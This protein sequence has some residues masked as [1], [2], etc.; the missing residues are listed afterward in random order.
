MAAATEQAARQQAELR[1]VRMERYMA[2]QAAEVEQAK[3]VRQLSAME[4][5]HRIRLGRRWGQWSQRR[6]VRIKH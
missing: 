2:G 6:A 3:R 5:L 4:E 1:Q